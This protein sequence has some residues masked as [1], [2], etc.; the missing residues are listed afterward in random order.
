[1]RQGIPSTVNLTY[2]LSAEIERGIVKPCMQACQS[3]AAP[4]DKL[5]RVTGIEPVRSAWEAD[6]L[7]LHFTSLEMPSS[8]IKL[9]D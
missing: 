9:P 1:M 8:R 5:E 4:C 2:L 3:M 6:R 7:P